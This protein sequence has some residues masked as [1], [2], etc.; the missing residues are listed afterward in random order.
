MTDL[1][2][3]K[4]SDVELSAARAKAD[5][6][7]LSL[8]AYMRLADIPRVDRGAIARAIRNRQPGMAV[9]GSVDLIREDRDAR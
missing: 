4:M 5:D 7:G 8:D 2:A 3:R 1:K 9:R 6:L